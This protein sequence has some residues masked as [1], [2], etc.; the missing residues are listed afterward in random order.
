ML[1]RAC[2][3]RIQERYKTMNCGYNEVSVCKNSDEY[4]NLGR[5]AK[6][7]PSRSI[8]IVDFM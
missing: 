6:I 8:L 7:S 2:V 5:C 3:S 1:D 4:W